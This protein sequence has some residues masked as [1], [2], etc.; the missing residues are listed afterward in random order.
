MQPDS[1]LFATGLNTGG[2]RHSTP[3]GATSA[4]SS[5]GGSCPQ[6]RPA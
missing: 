2:V 5:T 3:A 4:L 6:S 1:G